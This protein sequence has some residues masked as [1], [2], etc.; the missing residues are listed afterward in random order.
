MSTRTSTEYT[1]KDGEVGKGSKV[2]RTEYKCSQT[3]KPS[4]VLRCD[5][6]HDHSTL[7]AAEP[8]SSSP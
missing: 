5:M 6:D 8:R 3:S 1:Q 2:L 7:T 4:W